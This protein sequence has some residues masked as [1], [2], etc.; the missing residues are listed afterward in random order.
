MR[1]IILALWGTLL[2]LWAPTIHA[3]PTD[4]E[5]QIWYLAFTQGHIEEPFLYYL[6]AQPRLGER[7]GRVL[8]RSA[9]GLSLPVPGLSVWLG[10]A[11]IPV[12]D[13]G[14]ES[15]VRLNESRLYQQLLYT[16]RLGPVRLMSRSR[17]EQRLL[18]G[19][20]RPSH[21][22]RTLLRGS[23]PLDAEGTFSL[24]LW[25]E[26]FFHLNTVEGGPRA[27]FDQN[28]AFVGAGWKLSPHVTLELGYLNDF[29][30][31]PTAESHQMIHAPYVFTIFNYL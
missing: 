2:V 21:R 28:R 29:V 12:W 13:R 3:L 11:W 15:A 26:V 4:S 27:G 19:A 25:D 5:V 10:Y 18:A 14:E 8:L 31:R 22:F 23:H 24:I 16:P 7:D 17:L 30:R 6:E 1:S 9:L 20:S